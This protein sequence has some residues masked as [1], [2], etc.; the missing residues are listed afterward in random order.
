M[1]KA[2]LN[3]K[4]SIKLRKIFNN[5]KF[6]KSDLRKLF[7]DNEYEELLTDRFI[8]NMTNSE[9]KNKYFI[10][11]RTL[12]RIISSALDS[13]LKDYSMEGKNYEK[14]NVNEREELVVVELDD[15]AVNPREWDNLFTFIFWSKSIN[16]NNDNFS[17][18]DELLGELDLE[19]Y[20]ILPIY[21]YIHSN[22]SLKSG[23]IYE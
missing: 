4:N 11:E 17:N 7:K 18:P 12:Y 15:F 13:I 20:I 3:K 16:G 9:L 1:I 14:I 2:N 19:K 10:S 5:E 21:G 8:N 6:T 22:I 23:V